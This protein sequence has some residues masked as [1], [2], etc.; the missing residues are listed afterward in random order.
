MKPAIIRTLD[1]QGRIILPVEIRRTMGLSLGDVLEIRP[2]ENGVLLSK[3][4]RTASGNPLL[5]K[6]L[7]ILYSVSRCSCA[8]CTADEIL[9]A[10]GRYLPEGTEISSELAGYI[11][12]GKLT[13]FSPAIRAA[14]SDAALVDTLL[15]IHPTNTFWQPAALLL[16]QNDKKPVS[17]QDR[18]CA[19][20]IAALLSN[21]NEH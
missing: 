18:A 16:F 14:D 19:D 21:Q 20:L 8:I 10:K 2:V 9:M 3:Y 13:V 5:R 11:S 7:N 17:E 15:P 1:A 4:H 12:A 6:Y